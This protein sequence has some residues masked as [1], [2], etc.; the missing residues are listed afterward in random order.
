MSTCQARTRDDG[1]CNVGEFPPAVADRWA[2]CE[3]VPTHQVA[4]ECDC[5]HELAWEVCDDCAGVI[6][7]QMGDARLKVSCPSCRNHYCP[8][9]PAVRPLGVMA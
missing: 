1:I 6:L 3:G 2:A 7:G 9:F 5:E 8:V 4:S